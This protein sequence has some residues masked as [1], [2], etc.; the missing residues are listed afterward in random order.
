MLFADY[1]VL[2]DEDRKNVEEI[3]KNWQQVLKDDE[4]RITRANTNANGLVKAYA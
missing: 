2:E 4:L 3:L 1:V